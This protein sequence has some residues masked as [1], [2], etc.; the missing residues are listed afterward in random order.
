MAGIK[1]ERLGRNLSFWSAFAIGTG[2]M[3]GA[4]IFVLPG[5]AINNA[6]PAAVFSFILGGFLAMATALSL[7]E[8]ATGMPKAGG[9]YYFISRAMGPAF[10]TIIGLG[11]WLSLV[12]KGSFALIGLAE[13]LQAILPV[14]VLITAFVFGIILL[15]INYRGAESSGALQNIIVIGLFAILIIFIFRGAFFIERSKFIPFMPGGLSSVFSTTGLIFVSYLGIAKLAA[16]SEEVKDPDRNLPRAFI[17]SVAAV[18]LLYVGVMLIVNGALPLGRLLDTDTPLIDTAYYVAGGVGRIAIIIAGFFATVSTANAAVLSS[19]RF[20]FAMGRDKLMPRWFVDIHKRF[21]TPY[22]AI[23]ITG[24]SMVLLLLI[25]NVEQLAKLGSTFNVIIFVLVNLSVIVFRNNQPDWYNPSFR[26]PFY[27]FP[28]LL[29]IG[30]SLF[31]LPYLGIMAMVFA[32]GVILM[33]YLWYRVYGYNKAIPQYNLLDILED[34]PVPVS[35]DESKTRVLVSIAD[36]VHEFD[37]LKLAEMLGDKIIGLHVIKVPLQIDPEAIR[38]SHAKK[39]GLERIIEEE[40]TEE[41]ERMAKEHKYI[42]VFSHNI[43][44]TILEQ[45]DTEKSDLL[46][47]GWHRGNRLSDYLDNVAHKVISHANNNLAV[48]KG[49]F[50]DELK[51]ILIPYG[52]GPN[53][54]YALFLARKLALTSG[55]TVKLLRIISPEAEKDDKLKIENELKE[56]V[57]TGVNCK[58]E[59]E[60]KERY[61]PLDSIIEATKGVDLVIMGDEN[62]RFRL[63]LFGSLPERVAN[64]SKNPFVLVKRYRPI[65][66]EGF[67]AYF[68]QKKLTRR[69]N[70]RNE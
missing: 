18:T 53:A 39:P 65:S 60:L 47:L 50:P 36:P 52:G 68:K 57:E 46:L 10:G 2:T 37:L 27:P 31:L 4:G 54:R 32:A 58:I 55:A 61:S 56:V 26:D 69:K 43:A 59:Y 20:P 33:G 9:S 66:R 35:V 19:S 29:G 63:S 44:D 8:L 51:T 28:Q 22:R 49:R 70:Y 24:L 64:H 11:A 21:E 1:K 17:Y 14:P 7:S 6:G 30:G 34:N 16:I 15:I 67:K 3:I 23:L 62:R 45:L 38:E 25:F 5:V 13:Y 12:F 40:F 42:E 48:L 41:L